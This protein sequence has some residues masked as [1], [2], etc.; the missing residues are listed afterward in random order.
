MNNKEITKA[1]RAKSTTLGT[2]TNKWP[3]AGDEPEDTNWAEF[4]WLTWRSA[5]TLEMSS[6][7]CAFGCLCQVD[8]N[9]KLLFLFATTN[10]TLSITFLESAKFTVNIQSKTFHI[11]LTRDSVRNVWTSG[12]HNA[13]VVELSSD[14]ANACKLQDLLFLKIGAARSFEDVLINFFI[15]RIFYSFSFSLISFTQLSFTKQINASS[16][17]QE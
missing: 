17:N 6:G 16:S 12:R 8:F 7:K 10:S 2:S 3:V 14:F 11:P 1:T 5:C 9:G 15:L 4:E 13:G